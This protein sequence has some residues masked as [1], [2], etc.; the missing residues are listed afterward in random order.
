[1][2]FSCVLLSL[3]ALPSCLL[4][5]VQIV[6]FPTIDTFESIHSYISPT[7][8]TLVGWD[9]DN[10]LVTTPQ[11]L[12][13]DEW[14]YFNVNRRVNEGHDFIHALHLVLP[15][16]FFIQFN[17]PLIL[18]DAIIPHMLKRFADENVYTLALTARSLYI[19][20]RT[21]EQL[22]NISISF[23]L[24]ANVPT[25]FYL[26]LKNPAIYKGGILFSGNNDKGDVLIYFLRY[27]QLYPDHIVFI[28]DKDHN[29]ENVKIA[30]ES[31]RIRFTGL[32]YSGCDAKVAAFD[33]E[34]AER[35][36]EQLLSERIINPIH[37]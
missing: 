25:D 4:S 8:K 19:A 16:Y 24:P 7:E 30:V 9:L 14:F 11:E 37:A 1:M 17:S 21:I 15:T 12:G 36:M 26:P 27:T 31:N 20:D 28:D 2:L 3:F 23:H 13:S 6:Q 29:L 18:T 5:D 35:Q 34:Q 10:T 32:R 22:Q 33:P